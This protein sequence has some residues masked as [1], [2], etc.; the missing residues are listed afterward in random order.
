MTNH[1]DDYESY[2]DDNNFKIVDDEQYVDFRDHL[3][4]IIDRQTYVDFRDHLNKIIDRQTYN[5]NPMN[6][7]TI[8]MATHNKFI[9][10]Y[11][12]SG[13][14]PLLDMI[15][16]FTISQESIGNKNVPDPNYHREWLGSVN[17]IMDNDTKKEKEKEVVNHPEHYNPGPY[18]VIKIIEHYE[19]GFHLGNV[20]K[21]ILRA[22]VKNEN[23]YNEDLKKALWY[24]Q[25]KID[26]KETNNA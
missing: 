16:T 3:N 26:S 17:P 12:T 14:F 4:K 23:T 22:G 6:Q 25:R 2:T 15:P 10:E 7:G 24:L 1:Y 9:T 19:L 11:P 8:D 21:Y 20:I 18:E 13:N 5:K